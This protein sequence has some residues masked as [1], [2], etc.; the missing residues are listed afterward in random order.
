[1]IRK[2][3]TF[4]F[5]LALIVALGLTIV[6]AR[7]LKSAPRFT[8]CSNPCDPALPAF[9]DSTESKAVST[10]DATFAVQNA[11]VTARLT[12]A[13]PIEAV[14]RPLPPS[15]PSAYPPTLHRP[16]PFNS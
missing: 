6:P 8:A 12:G 10:I 4:A 9:Q 16:P 11:R 15:V 7:S 3:A 14:V 2:Y 13:S 5:G 1:M